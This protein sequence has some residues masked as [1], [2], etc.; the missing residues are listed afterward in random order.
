[1]SVTNTTNCSGSQSMVQACTNLCPKR[2]GGVQVEPVDEAHRGL[3][4]V[5]NYDFWCASQ[6]E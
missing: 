3:C 1:M 2:H 6:A 5:G 4:V